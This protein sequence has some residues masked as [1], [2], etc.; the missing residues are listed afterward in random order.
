MNDEQKET[1]SLFRWI[2][3][4]SHVIPRA[5]SEI[6]LERAKGINRNRYLRQLIEKIEA[7]KQ[8]QQ[9]KKPPIK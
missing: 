8:R 2:T 9:M 5:Q 1:Q 7:S 4:P 6:E 3:V